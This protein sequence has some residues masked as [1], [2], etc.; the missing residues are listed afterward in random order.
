MQPLCVIH[1]T[2]HLIGLR[3]D[4]G[5]C[6][7]E[8]LL[9]GAQTEQADCGHRK[10]WM[11]TACAIPTLP[12][13]PAMPHLQNTSNASHTSDFQAWLHTCAG[14]AKYAVPTCMTGYPIDMDLVKIGKFKLIT[15]RLGFSE[16][17]SMAVTSK[18]QVRCAYLSLCVP[19]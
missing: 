8:W 3:S 11:V 15:E 1:T 9:P 5:F 4:L 6:G 19:T 18:L 12:Y 2:S 13:T 14:D 7:L 16:D 10:S 17:G